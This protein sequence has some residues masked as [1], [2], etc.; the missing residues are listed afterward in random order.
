MKKKE[1]IKGKE[2]G[3]RKKQRKKEERGKE[4]GGENSV[5]QGREK[6]EP[7][8]KGRKNREIREGKIGS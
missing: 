8:W 7:R 1:E 2:R 4:K 6:L 3:G 5:K